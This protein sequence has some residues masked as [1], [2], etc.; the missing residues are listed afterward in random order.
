MEERLDACLR[1]GNCPAGLLAAMRYS[2]FAGGKRIRP[3][4]CVLSARVPAPPGPDLADAVLTFACALEC[5]HTYSLI[6]DDL[7]AMDDDDFRR[8]RPSCHRQF[9]EAS[10]ILAGDALLTDAFALAAGCAGPALPAGRVL[11]AVAATAKAAGSAGMVGGQFLDMLYTGG[12]E[13]GL[14]QTAAARAGK[15]DAAPRLEKAATMQ[16]EQSDAVP[17]TGQTAVAR[18]GK[19]DA[20]PRLEKAASLRT[21]QSGTA[22]NLEEL[23]AMQAMKTGAMLRLPCEVGAMLAGAC[24]ETAGALARYGAAL[25]AAFQITDDILDVAGDAALL[26]KPVG[27]DSAARKCTYPSL[28]GLQKSREIAEQHAE[29]AVTALDG[30]EGESAALLRGLAAYVV[31]RVF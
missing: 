14:E 30:L 21:G 8:G 3:V 12:T 7:P 27:S 2:L 28:L 1:A 13:P 20:V 11:R 26:G 23:A 4:L 15:N 17:R 19:N 24:P 25:G 9:D 16:V 10:A 29:R 6:H 31:N 5:I 18:A 22:P